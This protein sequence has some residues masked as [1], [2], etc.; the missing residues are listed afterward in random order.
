MVTGTVLDV[1]HE[2][3]NNPRFHEMAEDELHGKV[4][5]TRYCVSFCF[6]LVTCV[7]YNNR[8]YRIAGIKWDMTPE[9]TFTLKSGEQITFNEYFKTHYNRPLRDTR[10]PLL[11]VSARKGDKKEILLPPELCCM[12]V[13]DMRNESVI[14]I[15]Y[16]RV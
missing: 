1:L 6:C 4:V 12:T 15:N 2:L 11:S 3:S 5:L 9:S 7:R 10:Q 13:C 16:H 8:T 14:I